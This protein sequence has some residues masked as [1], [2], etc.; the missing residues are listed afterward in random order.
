[1]NNNK[2]TVAIIMMGGGARA[3][4]Q[5]GVL[6]AIAKWLPSREATPFKIICGTSAGAIN[7]AAVASVADDFKRAVR[8]LEAV[9]RNFRVQQ[10]FRA[11]AFGVA[12]TSLNWFSAMALG[13]FGR[14]NPL[15]L[16]DRKPLFELLHRTMDMPL[17]QKQID[18]G[19]LRAFSV[20]A[21]GYESGHSVTFFQADPTID[22]WRRVRRMGARSTIS[23]RHLM[24]SS[25]IPFI[26]EP[27]RVHREYFGDG[28]MRQVAPLSAAVHLGAERV[29]VIGNRLESQ[30]PNQRVEDDTPPSIA[31]IAGHILNSIFLDSLEADLERLERIN[32]TISLI[33]PENRDASTVSLREVESLLISPSKDLGAMAM[34]HAYLMPWPI[35]LLLRGIGAQRSDGSEL[36]SYLLFEAAYCRDLIKLGY[37][38]AVVQKDAILEFLDI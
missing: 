32:R 2:P 30:E 7:A 25:A 1:M 9:W 15:F 11:D 8:R 6:K 37:Q 20:T 13:G 19:L 17:I 22:S 18:A 26:F 29:L 4:Y 27:V 38:N 33:P 10:V 12:R 34:P 23:V 21:S 14:R 5:V 16:L 36:I 31:Q 28:S 3:A 24:A 35:K